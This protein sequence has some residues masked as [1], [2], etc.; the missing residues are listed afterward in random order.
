MEIKV[1]TQEVSKKTPQEEEEHQI[2]PGNTVLCVGKHRKQNS[3]FRSTGFFLQQ[4]HNVDVSSYMLSQ[5]SCAPNHNQT[6]SKKTYCARVS[7]T[8]AGHLAFSFSMCRYCA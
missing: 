1:H 6:R 3:H 5:W 4:R 2:F 7:S 8:G